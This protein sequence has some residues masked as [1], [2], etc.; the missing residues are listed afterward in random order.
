VRY[1]WREGAHLN[2]DPAAVGKIVEGIER[3]KNGVV[4][5][6]D[7]VEAAKDPASPIHKAF[8]WDDALAAHEHRLSQARQLLRCLVVVKGE[9]KEE[10]VERVYVALRDKEGGYRP[11][12]KVMADE[13]QRKRLLALA[14]AE[15]TVVMRKY[16]HLEEL[17][18]VHEA[19]ERARKQADDQQAG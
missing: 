7:V 5:A 3:R 8:E 11:L 15:L 12:V 2:V 4:L 10:K 18:S 14:F 6:N 13:G 16:K 19:I 17:A 9:E 1:A